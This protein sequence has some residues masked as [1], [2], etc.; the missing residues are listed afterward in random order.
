MNI[1]NII[2]GLLFTISGLM[3]YILISVIA[4][5]IY[6]QINSQY[7]FS[8][9][10][11]FNNLFILFPII[12]IIEVITYSKLI[13]KEKLNKTLLFTT[14]FWLILFY[15]IIIVFKFIL[16]DSYADFPL[17]PEVINSMGL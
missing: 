9:T 14:G 4:I 6:S 11:I 13:K 2:L 16:I 5:F 15:I 3:L 7:L 17:S 1:W 10:K 12:T 8:V